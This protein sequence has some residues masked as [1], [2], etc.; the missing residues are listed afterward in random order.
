MESSLSHEYVRTQYPN[1]LTSVGFGV[2]STFRN[3]CN[4]GQIL[5]AD[6]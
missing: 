2:Q 5:D 6:K 3:N 1:L 4:L